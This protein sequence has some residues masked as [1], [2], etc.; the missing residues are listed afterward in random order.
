MS[1]TQSGMTG[2]MLTCQGTSTR[3]Q[4]LIPSRNSDK[5]EFALPC[6]QRHTSLM[7]ERGAG[8][9]P[10]GNLP[11][12]VRQPTCMKLMLLVGNF[13]NTKSCK[14]AQKWLKLWHIGTHLRVF[15]ESYPMNTNMTGFGRFSKIFVSLCFG[16]QMP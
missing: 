7:G 3:S 2:C 14:K 15:G 5:C 10:D 11:F 4:V 8:Q 16:Q 12:I 1:V 13:A 6:C 9:G